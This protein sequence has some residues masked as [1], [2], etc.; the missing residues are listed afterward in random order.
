MLP[1]LPCTTL[2]PDFLQVCFHSSTGHFKG[3]VYT[4]WTA[5]LLQHPLKVITL[6]P[7]HVDAVHGA[8]TPCCPGTLTLLHNVTRC[9]LG[10]SY[11]LAGA[12][13]LLLL[14]LWSVWH[15]I[16]TVSGLT[17]T[18]REG[19]YVVRRRKCAAATCCTSL[20]TS[21]PAAHRLRVVTAGQHCS[22]MCSRG[23]CWNKRNNEC[24]GTQDICF[25]TRKMRLK[26]DPRT[27]I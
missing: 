27:R 10:A 6:C 17:C 23:Y 9:W 14:W 4:F 15:G 25:L 8:A 13:T 18:V 22:S 24:S 19:A 11:R 21:Q 3:T 16:N 5:I 7:Q 20:F 2:R 26:R 1:F 12:Q